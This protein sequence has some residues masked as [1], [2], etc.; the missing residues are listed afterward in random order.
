MKS[1]LVLGYHLF[2]KQRMS[3]KV[4]TQLD[5]LWI[6]LEPL[7]MAAVF[8]FLYK[9][10]AINVG[11]DYPYSLFIITGILSWQI[12]VECLNTPMND[13]VKFKEVGRQIEISPQ[14]IAFYFLIKSL[15]YSLFKL[16]IIVSFVGVLAGFKLIPVLSFFIFSILLIVLF[17]GLGMIFAPYNLILN[18]IQKFINMILR[19]LMFASG[20]LFAIPADTIFFE[21][22]QFNPFYII[23]EGLRVIL[24]TEFNWQ[25]ISRLTFLTLLM[26]PL[27]AYGMWTFC[28]GFKIA[29]ESQ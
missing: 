12:L 25:S 22:N 15:Y 9:Y 17:T 1:N 18:D 20:V 5:Q 7:T 2:T 26:F 28:S 13:M 10:R 6:W 27:A 19:P 21:L 8:W 11:T 23:I 3:D 24:L 4:N 29:I 16:I 14:S